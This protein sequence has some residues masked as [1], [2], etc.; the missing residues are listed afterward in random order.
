MSPDE[1]AR[2]HSL[3]EELV[4]GVIKG[5]APIDV[6]LAALFGR[7]FSLGADTWLRMEARYRRELAQ[8]AAIYAAD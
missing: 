8:K 2:Q 1:F 7:E 4:A 5:S 6:D 3:P